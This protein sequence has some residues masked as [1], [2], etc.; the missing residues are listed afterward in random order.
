MSDTLVV[1]ALVLGGSAFTRWHRAMLI[2][3]GK[4]VA[5]GDELHLATLAVEPDV[6]DLA[7]RVVLPGFVDAHVHPTSGGQERITCGLTDGVTIDD[8][9]DTIAAWARANAETT[10]IIGAGWSMDAFPGGVPS[11]SHLAGVGGGRP[12]FLMN[13]DGHSAWV[14][15]EALAL[16][17]IGVDT[18]DPPGGRIERGADGRPSGAL[19]ELAADLVR[20]VIPADEVPDARRSLRAGHD[21]LVSLGITS[22]EDAGVRTSLGHDIAYR[23]MLDDGSLRATVEGAQW[24]PADFADDVVDAMVE[25]RGRFSG[26]RVSMGSVKIMLDGVLETHTAHLKQPYLVSGAGEERGIAFFDPDRLARVAVVLDRLGF[27]LHFHAV[28]DAALRQAIDTVAR[29]RAENGFT[30]GVHHVAH[31]QVVDPSDLLDLRRVGLAAN[32]QTLWARN[33]PYV[34]ELAI[35]VLGPL[36]G[37]TQYPFASFLQRGIAL[38]MGSDWPVS[39]PRPFHQLHVAVN[40]LPVPKPATPDDVEVFVPSERLALIDAIRAFTIG[41]A[42]LCRL[43]P[44]KG[45][46]EVGKD[47][48]FI[49]LDRD[50]F[51]IDPTELHAVQVEETWIEGE[52]VSAGEGGVR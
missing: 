3:N 42:T 8:Y 47:A 9:R 51:A 13:R 26:S 49:V 31:L 36:R 43:D 1:N 27:N 20:A 45:S 38:G 33:E 24:L 23:S 35:P 34:T 15:E 16:A 29:C 48:D 5:L 41:S 39:T 10:W 7:G 14:N 52:L 19:H 6:V 11:A 4:L 32:A 17:G 46:L 12:I 28:G 21:W 50:P 30:D 18:P 22:W 37:A 2:R 40:R 25:M 44:R